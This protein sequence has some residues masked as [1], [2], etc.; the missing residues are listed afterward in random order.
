MMSEDG[1]IGRA[2]TNIVNPTPS[3]YLYNSI[4]FMVSMVSQVENH[5]ELT[6]VH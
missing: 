3:G 5:Q 4:Y 6:V 1:Q 2:V